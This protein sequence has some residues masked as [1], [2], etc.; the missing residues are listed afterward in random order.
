MQQENPLL[1]KQPAVDINHNHPEATRRALVG[2][3]AF[4]LSTE[5]A[6]HYHHNLW[7]NSSASY[8]DKTCDSNVMYSCCATPLYSNVNESNWTELYLI[9]TSLHTPFLKMN[10]FFDYLY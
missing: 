1:A 6:V 8:D 7:F 10:S 5:S 2:K 9:L 4:N 3:R